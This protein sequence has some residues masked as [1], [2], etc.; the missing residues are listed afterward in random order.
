MSRPTRTGR[1]LSI[2]H[3]AIPALLLLPLAVSGCDSAREA[4]GL[5]KKSPDE[6]A[7]VTRAPLVLP[8]E[9]GLRPPQ[10]GAPRPQEIQARDRAQ[11]ALGGRPGSGGLTQQAGGP[12]SSARSAG[13]AALLQQAG[14]TNTDPDIRRKVNDEFTQLAERDQSFVDRLVFWQQP[15]PPGVAVDPVKEAQRLRENAAT[16]KPVTAGNVPTIKRRERGPLE[17]IF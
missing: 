11:A 2:Q 10:P 12:T 17:G 16:G 3:L 15:E 13:E 4:M 6:F 7:V 9:F 1:R 8:P 14:A 5:N